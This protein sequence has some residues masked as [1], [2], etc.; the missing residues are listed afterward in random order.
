MSSIVGLMLFL[1][2]APQ[3]GASAQGES[4]AKIQ[5]SPNWRDGQF[6]NL[7]PTPMQSPDG[8]MFEAAREYFKGGV[9]RTPK[10]PP[11]IVK[12]NPQEIAAA[13]PEEV[14]ITWLGHSSVLIQIDGKSLLTDPMFGKRA[15][16]VPLLG[17]KRFNAELPLPPENIPHLDA[18]ILSHDHYDHLDY[19]TIK[20]LHPKTERFFVPLGVGAHLRRW[21]V[22]EAK[23]V[24]LD[25]WDEFDFDGLRLV[26]APSRHFSGRGMRDRNRT[27]WC[28]WMLF[29]SENLYFGG[30]SGYGPH[31]KEIGQRFGPFDLTLLE[32]GAYSRYWPFV[33]MLPEQTAQAHQDLRGGVLLPIHWGQFN[34]SLHSWTEPIERLLK[35][36][37]QDN[38]DVAMPGIGEIFD[39]GG[40]VPQKRWWEKNVNTEGNLLKEGHLLEIN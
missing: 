33:H 26:A 2:L 32:N 31:F 14:R 3:F 12:M 35:K 1:R 8:S 38:I 19:G 40:D 18:I 15:S 24:E 25:W 11:P 22:A 39:L 6:I 9:E 20:K 7:M 27:L 16:P 34:L 21:G 5:S 13:K 28:S 37:G 29:G 36:A 4:L 17:P 30:D 10:T 23:I